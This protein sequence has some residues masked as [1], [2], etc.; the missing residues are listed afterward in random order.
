MAAMMVFLMRQTKTSS[1]QDNPEYE[2]CSQSLRRLSI[3][4]GQRLDIEDWMV[5]VY[6][7]DREEKIGS[8]GLYVPVPANINTFWLT[9]PHSGDVYRGIWHKTQVALK[10]I[11]TSGGVTPTS[12][13]YTYPQYFFGL[14]DISLKAVLRETKVIHVIL[15]RIFADPCSALVDIATSEHFAYVYIPSSMPVQCGLKQLIISFPWC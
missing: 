12:Q 5:T 10:M 9:L 13:V 14:S 7:V 2:F 4:S 11:R 1:S 15:I 8:G 3:M 6:D